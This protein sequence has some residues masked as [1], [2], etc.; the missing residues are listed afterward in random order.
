VTDEPAPISPEG[1]RALENELADLR[2]ERA[3]VAATLRSGDGVGDQADEADELQRVSAVARLDRRIRQLEDRLR[4]GTVAGS[5][6]TDAVGVGSA[7]TVRFADG[8]SETFEISELANELDE[9]LVTA[10]SPLGHALLGHRPGD[11]VAYDTP[12][13]RATAT[14]VSIG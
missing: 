7:V 10:D 4:E 8:S 11:T 12:R 14:I 2:S 3:S 5:P 6:A 13:G 9:S 1:R